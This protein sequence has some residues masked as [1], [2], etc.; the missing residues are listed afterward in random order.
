ML[1]GAALAVVALQRRNAKPPL[2][3]AG[4]HGTC[5]LLGYAALLWALRGPARGAATGTQSFGPAAAVL[6]LVA[7]ALGIASLALH[8]RRRRLPGFWAGAHASVAIFGYVLLAV[9][10]LLG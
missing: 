6:L 5:A 2:W 9:Y 7:A 8:I 1:L 10:L 3:L 4:L